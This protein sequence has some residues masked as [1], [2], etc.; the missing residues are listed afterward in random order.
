MRR[1]KPTI[2]IDGAAFSDLEGFYDEIE[3]KLAG[4]ADWPRTLDALDE[5]LSMPP[6]PLPA[7]IRV[8][9]EHSD[10]SRRRLGDHGSGSFIDLIDRIARHPNIELILS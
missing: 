2:T 5:L 1:E 8:V 6:A 9:W 7:E 10:L 4:D 3:S